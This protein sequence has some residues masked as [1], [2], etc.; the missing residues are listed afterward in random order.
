MLVI[1]QVSSA[2]QCWLDVSTGSNR[3]VVGTKRLFQDSLG[4]NLH[5]I[6]RH[7]TKPEVE[8]VSLKKLVTGFYCA[9]SV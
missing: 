4:K 3:F 6:A 1:E 7:Y 8:T 2:V 5:F 9:V